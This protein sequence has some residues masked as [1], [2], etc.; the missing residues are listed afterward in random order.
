MKVPINVHLP[1]SALV[2]AALGG[3]FFGIGYYI[4]VTE[5]RVSWIDEK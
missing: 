2:F 1:M 5:T 4:L 3:M